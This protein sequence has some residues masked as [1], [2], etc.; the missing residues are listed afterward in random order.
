[1]ASKTFDKLLSVLVMKVINKDNVKERIDHI[2][3]RPFSNYEQVSI[4]KYIIS[5]M[6][7]IILPE[8]DRAKVV[9]KSSFCGFQDNFG[10]IRY[11]CMH[12]ARFI[13]N[14]FMSIIRH[15]EIGVVLK[16]MNS[17]Q[18][19]ST[20][21]M[22]LLKACRQANMS[23]KDNWH[24]RQQSIWSLSNNRNWNIKNVV[25][26]MP[27]F[28]DS[29]SNI[30]MDAFRAKSGFEY[31]HSFNKANS[32]LKNDFKLYPFAFMLNLDDIC[33]CIMDI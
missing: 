31:N 12:P 19:N 14:R 8:K 3:S 33:S 4:E 6:R 1:M 25:V 20:Y 22:E 28:N 15:G 21:R 7:D 27:S 10:N 23:P 16:W 11:S 17:I 26:I 5:E 9:L 13:A 18:E 24:S 30:S 2:F 29:V 32:F